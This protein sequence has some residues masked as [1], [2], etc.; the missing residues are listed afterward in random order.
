[1][2]GVPLPIIT[3]GSTPWTRLVLLTLVLGT[4]IYRVK[5]KVQVQVKVKGGGVPGGSWRIAGLRAGFGAGPGR[6]LVLIIA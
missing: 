2:H 4:H 3:Q 1:M 5:V 6:E